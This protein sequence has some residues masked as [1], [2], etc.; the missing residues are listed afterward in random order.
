MNAA[1][2]WKAETL[3]T[4]VWNGGNRFIKQFC[5]A[6]HDKRIVGVYYSYSCKQCA[7]ERALKRYRKVNRNAE[8]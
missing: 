6:G 2:W 7:R 5:P 3:K 4:F 1:D 8:T